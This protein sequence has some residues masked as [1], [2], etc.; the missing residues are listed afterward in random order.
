LAGDVELFD[1][2]FIG[3][4]AGTTLQFSGVLEGGGFTKVGA[5]TVIVSGVNTYFGPTA[6]AA[7]VLEVQNNQPWEPRPQVQRC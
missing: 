5:G 2:G 4:D 3:A 6:V 7:G 1:V